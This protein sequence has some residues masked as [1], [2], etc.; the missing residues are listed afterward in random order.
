MPQAKRRIVFIE[1]QVSGSVS[2]ERVFAEVARYLPDDL[3]EIEFQKMSH[4]NGLVGIVKNLCS[5]RKR[6]ADIFHITGHIHYMAMVLPAGKTVLTIHDL[7]FMH[8]RTGL[9]RYFIKKFFLDWPLRRLKHLSAVSETTRDEIEQ[10]FP[11]AKGLVRVIENPVFD[12]FVPGEIKA[13]RAECPVILQ[14]GTTEN[15]NVGILV[16]AVAGLN[17]KLRIIGSLD[18]A[19]IDELKANATIFENVRSVDDEQI[20]EEYR[21]ADIIAFCSTYEGFGLPIIEA[22]AMRKPVITS[23]LAPMNAVAGDGAVLV[24][25]MD[26]A[27]VR[28]AIERLIGDAEFRNAIIK[29]GTE[30][31]KR[32]E[33]KA[34]ANRYCELYQEIL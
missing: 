25:P 13:F 34:V 1:R 12:S 21:N 28:K 9:R 16:K 29:Q 31:V 5:F 33:P 3:Y 6:D 7:V 20:V 32:F 14:I 11:A 27:S 24:D 18:A 19:I 8:N 2:I 4:G 23:D 26:A 10:S 15:K 22:Q 17:C 30:N